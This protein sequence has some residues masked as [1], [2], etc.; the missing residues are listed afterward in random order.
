MM[1][2]SIRLCENSKYLEESNCNCSLKNLEDY[3][4]KVC[5]YNN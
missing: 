3:P 2:P 1:C 5:L 4:Y